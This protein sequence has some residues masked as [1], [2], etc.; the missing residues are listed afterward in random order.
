VARKPQPASAGFY[1]RIADPAGGHFA[2]IE[3]SDDYAF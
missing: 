1:A 2:V 3:L